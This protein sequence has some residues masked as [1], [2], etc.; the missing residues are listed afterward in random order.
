MSGGPHV[1]KLLKEGSQ[2]KR[3]DRRCMIARQMASYIRGQMPRHVTVAELARRHEMART[4][5]EVILREFEIP[6]Q[7]QTVNK[8]FDKGAQLRVIALLQNT[9]R[10]QLQISKDCGVTQ[11]RVEQIV[12]V[13]RK[14][15]IRFP[16]RERKK[17]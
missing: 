16:N 15:G 14:A 11:R 8:Q 5:V 13:S 10:T 3:H 1:L 12:Y 6:Y 4:T 7:K 9:N 17:R 2:A